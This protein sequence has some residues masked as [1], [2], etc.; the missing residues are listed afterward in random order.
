M[1]EYRYLY[2]YGL[3]G[4]RRRLATASGFIFAGLYMDLDRRF[5]LYAGGGNLRHKKPDPWP[6]VFG[7]HEIFHVFVLV[8]S[9]CHFW[10]MYRYIL[11]L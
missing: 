10:L 6:R 9:F 2:G 8:G 11:E 1:V 3:A 4:D 7:F 5:L